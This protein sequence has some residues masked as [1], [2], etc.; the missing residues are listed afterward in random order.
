[1]DGQRTMDIDT[2][3][4]ADLQFGTASR[5]FKTK[6]SPRTGMTCVSHPEHMQGVFGTA[7]P[8]GQ[9]TGI[10]LLYVNFNKSKKTNDFRVAQKSSRSHAQRLYIYAQTPQ[11]HAQCLQTQLRAGQG[12]ARKQKNHPR[13][14]KRYARWTQSS[15]GHHNAMRGAYKPG[16]GQGIAVR[17]NKKTTQPNALFGQAG[18]SLA[19]PLADA[20]PGA[21]GF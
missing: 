21:Y 11:C 3:C 19:L 20:C 8:Q 12:R 18:L 9:K 14:K 17:T 2:P 1:M 13:E 15:K 6:V 7:E 5:P 16:R 10:S 4:C